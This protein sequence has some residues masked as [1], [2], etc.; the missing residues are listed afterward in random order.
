MW[1]GDTPMDFMLGLRR[2]NTV[3]SKMVYHRSWESSPYIHTRSRTMALTP[4][5][6]APSIFVINKKECEK[7]TETSGFHSTS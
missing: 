4:S 6:P 3:D 2:E 7:K 5:T 1:K